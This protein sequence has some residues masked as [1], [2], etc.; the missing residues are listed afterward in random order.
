MVPTRIVVV[1]Q[2][3]YLLHSDPCLPHKPVK[4][5]FKLKSLKWCLMD[6]EHNVKM[7]TV[8]FS[9]PSFCC[10]QRYPTNNESNTKRED[11]LLI[12]GKWEKNLIQFQFILC[13]EAIRSDPHLSIV[14][15]THNASHSSFDFLL[16]RR[17]AHREHTSKNNKYWNILIYYLCGVVIVVN[18][19]LW[20]PHFKYAIT[21]LLLFHWKWFLSPSLYL[22]VSLPLFSL[23]V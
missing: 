9:F 23:F 12:G 8:R 19:K 3:T 21:I 4:I 17:T 22:S 7:E 20:R 1:F 10:S 15:S 14:L 18:C 11:W 2:H 13:N 6:I 16:D 5:Y